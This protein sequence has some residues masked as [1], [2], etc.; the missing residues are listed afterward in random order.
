MRPR[1]NSHRPVV[2]V[3][4]LKARLSLYL[5]RVRSGHEIV[6][7][8]HGHPVA[9]LVPLPAGNGEDARRD[10]LIRDGLLQPARRRPDIRFWLK[11]SPLRDTG[12]AARRALIHERDDER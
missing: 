10:R 6:V 7:T 8:D 12:G 11:P 4:D 3:A 5:D 1:R 2:G 9:R